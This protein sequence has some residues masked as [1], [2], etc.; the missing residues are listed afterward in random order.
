MSTMTPVI[1]TDPSNNEQHY[2]F[3]KGDSYIDPTVTLL[4]PINSDFEIGIKPM[5][6]DW[7]EK[8][9]YVCIVANYR[10]E[11]Q[12]AVTFSEFYA[13]EGVGELTVLQ[14]L[15]I[16]TD[17]AKLHRRH[18]SGGYIEAGV[19]YCTLEEDPE[20][21]LKPRDIYFHQKEHSVLNPQLFQVLT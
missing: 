1:V 13:V 10:D 4:K 6:E 9:A 20:Y 21:G 17:L 15:A 12:T 2:L 8:K 19:M 18:T 11:A 7:Y 3:L 5:V 16:V 14:N